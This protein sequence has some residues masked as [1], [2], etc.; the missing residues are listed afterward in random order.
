MF[1]PGWGVGAR[2]PIVSKGLP[3]LRL[4]LGLLLCC[5]GLCVSVSTAVVG[6][7]ECQVPRCETPEKAGLSFSSL[8]ATEEMAS[9]PLDGV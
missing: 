9:P 4:P 1:P 8:A 7:S 3:A 2:G 5:A 6:A